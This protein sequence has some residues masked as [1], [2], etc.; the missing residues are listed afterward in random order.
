MCLSGKSQGFSSR[1]NAG[2][3][4]RNRLDSPRAVFLFVRTQRPDQEQVHA[5]IHRGELG[6]AFPPGDLFALELDATVLEFSFLFLSVS[7]IQFSAPVGGI[8]SR[9]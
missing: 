6:D 9:E 1:S 3:T 8:G 5:V 4:Q 2:R 7:G